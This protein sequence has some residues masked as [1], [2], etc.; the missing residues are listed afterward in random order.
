[1]LLIHNYY[2][3]VNLA[4]ILQMIFSPPGDFI[5]FFLVDDGER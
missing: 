4:N 3:K 2:V 1:M 5:L